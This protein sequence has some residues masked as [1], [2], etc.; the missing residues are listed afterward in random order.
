M[1]TLIFNGSPR[2]NGDTASLVNKVLEDLNGEFKIVNAYDCG[3]QP[4]MDCRYCW[5]NRGC[6]INDSM[7]E[8]YQY[9]QEC[10]NVI[11]ASPIYFSVRIT[12]LLLKTKKR[13]AACIASSAF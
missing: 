6:R 7:R 1:K 5:E 2:K 8:I 11:I 13:C 12:S 4:C 10:D 3:V 9:I